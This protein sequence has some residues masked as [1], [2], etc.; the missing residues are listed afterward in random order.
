EDLAVVVPPALL[1]GLPGQ[2]DQLFELVGLDPVELKHVPHVPGGHPDVPGLDPA[3]LGGGAFQLLAD[4]VDGEFGEVTQASQLTGE[5]AA[6]D[7]RAVAPGHWHSSPR[8][9][10]DAAVA[11]EAAPRPPTSGGQCVRHFG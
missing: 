3:D 7:G 1:A 2:L 4:L 6:S 10:G 8:T 5:P 9:C 11:A